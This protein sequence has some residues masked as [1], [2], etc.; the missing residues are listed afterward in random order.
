MM[1]ENIHDLLGYDGI[2]IIQRPDMFCFSLDSILL[3]DFI[4]VNDKS[5]KIIDLGTGNG[6]I[7]LFLSLKTK[8]NIYGVEIQE[9]VADLATRSVLMNKLESQISILNKDIKNISQTLEP[10]SFDIVCSNP[11]YFKY[12]PSSNINKNDYLTIA[13]HEVKITLEEIIE[14]ARKLLTNQGVFYMVHRS[15]R[16]MEIMQLMGQ[17][18]MQV[19]KLRFIY[20][21]TTSPHSAMVLIKAIKGAKSGLKVQSPLYVYEGL[22]YTPEVLKIFN[23]NKQ[24]L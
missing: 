16:L 8:A 10:N 13:R 17:N 1:T 18:K 7:P 24:D 3:A 9:A 2:K 22:N 4:E 5:R 12:L 15:E 19:K 14:E 21:K 6:P 23:F 11:P 20:T